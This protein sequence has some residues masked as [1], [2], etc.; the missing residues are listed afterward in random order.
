[1]RIAVF[2]AALSQVVLP[3][4]LEAQVYPEYYGA[5]LVIENYSQYRLWIWTESPDGRS[6]LAVDQIEPGPGLSGSRPGV[7]VDA[8]RLILDETTRVCL[9]AWVEDSRVVCWNIYA[10]RDGGRHLI[11]VDNEDFLGRMF[12]PDQGV[13]TQPNPERLL[14]SEAAAWR[15]RCGHVNQYKGLLRVIPI[16][17][18]RGFDRCFEEACQWGYRY[19]RGEENIPAGYWTGIGKTWYVWKEFRANDREPWRECNP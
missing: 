18:G 17:E 10:S 2:A 1:M 11:T 7:T 9:Q 4:A 6:R 14:D 3:F 5:D 19:Y 13:E 12:N 16:T 15:E 8:S